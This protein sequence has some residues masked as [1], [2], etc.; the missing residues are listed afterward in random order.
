MVK[1]NISNIVVTSTILFFIFLTRFNHELT[2]F[3]LP[4][5][6][7]IIAF[8]AGV[9]LKEIKY[10]IAVI[11]GIICLDSYA[12]YNHGYQ[13]ISLFNASYFFHLT[14]YPMAWWLSYKLKIFDLL[15]FTAIILAVVSLGFV[16]SYGSYFY[17]YDMRLSGVSNFWSYLQN[18]FSSYFLTNIIYAG[19][20]FLGHKL[21]AKLNSVF[22][23][24]FASKQFYLKN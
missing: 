22:V 5:A 2:P 15:N 20:F 10:L 17:L 24:I 21:Y 16:I 23:N 8:A 1:N 4:D 6:S 19:L 12:I 11:L 9:L 7:L 18:N 3:A 13:N 14:T